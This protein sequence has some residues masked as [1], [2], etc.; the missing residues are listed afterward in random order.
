MKKILG[1]VLYA[2]VM[3]GVTAGLGM[4][5]MKKSAPPAAADAEEE[6]SESEHGEVAHD[7]TDAM[8]T[9]AHGDDSHGTRTAELTSRGDASHGSDHGGHDGGSASGHDEQLPVAVRATPMSVEEIVRMGLSLKSRDEVVRKR[10]AAL[11]DIESQQRLT[12]A[13]LAAAQQNVENL[14]AQTSDQR[15]AKEELLSRITAQNQELQREREAIA[16]ERDVLKKEREEFETV[17][18]QL[19]A[20]KTALAQNESD[21]AIKRN[22]VDTDRK[23]FE[24]ERTRVTLDGEK[25]VKEREKWLA[26]K[27]K[28]AEEKKQITLDRDALRVERDLFEQEKRGLATTTPAPADTPKP[29]KG[30]TAGT[31]EDATRTK[32]WKKVADLLEVMSPETAAANV[33][34]LAEGGNTDLVVDVLM[35]M[36]PRKSGPIMDALQDEK[37]ASDF[38]LKMSN[39]NSNSKTTKKP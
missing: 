9:E 10:E 5:M 38:L 33:R 22:A 4:F 34:A 17:K 26:D 21:L 29:A 8:G 20:Q 18:N 31:L 28:I 14:L 39:R 27:E 24:D 11:R 2:G 12:L 19:D 7:D 35:L 13:D 6:G 15:A 3:F 25:L 36:E 16:G 1:L 32:D 30:T 23:M 37:L